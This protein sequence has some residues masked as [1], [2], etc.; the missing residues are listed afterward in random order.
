M[1]YVGGQLQVFLGTSIGVLSTGALA[2]GATVWQQEAATEIGNVIVSWMDY[3]SADRTLA[4]ATH[5]R[6]VFTTQ[7]TPTVGVGDGSPVASQRLRLGQSFPNPAHRFAT[8]AYELPR[9]CDVSLRLFD[10]AGRIAMILVDGPQSQGRHEVRLA[11]VG[12]PS[13]AYTYVLRAGGAVEMRS[14]LLTR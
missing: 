2:G 7:F 9:G 6:G 5:A 4:V 12:L 1:F 13:G 11:P 14:L 3:R 10:A 8:I